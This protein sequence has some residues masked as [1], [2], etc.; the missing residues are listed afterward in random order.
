MLIYKACNSNLGF[1][2]I[3]PSYYPG[4]L[5][6]VYSEFMTKIYRRAVSGET[7]I[8]GLIVVNWKIAPSA[9]VGG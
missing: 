3:N 1:A 4:D 9:K 5:S 8:L 2:A 7:E 6:S